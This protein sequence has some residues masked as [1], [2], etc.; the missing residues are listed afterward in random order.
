MKM[1]NRIVLDYIMLL[2]LFA[3]MMKHAT[4]V[5]AH[6]ILGVAFA[7]LTVI[8]C[9]NNKSWIK[10]IGKSIR[11]RKKIGLLIVNSL[12]FVSFI[13][14]TVSGIMI[15]VVLLR[16]LDIPYNERFFKMH[17]W[18]S[19]FLLGFSLVHLLMHMKMI[20]AF[21]RNN[22]RINQRRAK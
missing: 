3:L 17:A 8:H 13:L 9:Y 11:S 22:K 6:E 2:M 5:F 4:G 7:L 20:I 15:S 21:F 18:S 14:A 12:L 19:R 10:N 1:E 16:F